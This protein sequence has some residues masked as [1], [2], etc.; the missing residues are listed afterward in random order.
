MQNK[1]ICELVTGH[2]SNYWTT[3][4]DQL[5]RD[6]QYKRMCAFRNSIWRYFGLPISKIDKQTT[7]KVFVLWREVG[8]DNMR[9]YGVDDLIL[10]FRYNLE[11]FGLGN[12]NV[13]GLIK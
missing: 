2:N 5:D 3:E 9:S 11:V 6:D 4:I 10:N 1:T 7:L 8:F 12:D 13:K